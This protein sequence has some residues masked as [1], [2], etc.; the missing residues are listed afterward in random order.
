MIYYELES[1]SLLT[2]RCENRTNIIQGY[3]YASLEEKRM[4]LDD[5]KM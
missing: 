2:K 1:T 5:A 4:H 3:D